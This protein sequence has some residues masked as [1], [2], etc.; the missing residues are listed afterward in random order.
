M[1]VE[2]IEKKRA[3]FRIQSEIRKVFGEELRKKDF[4]EISPVIISTITDPLNH[5]I[6]PAKINSPV[7]VSCTEVSISSPSPP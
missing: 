7:V 3:V 2:K 1:N 5:P 4:I 6:V